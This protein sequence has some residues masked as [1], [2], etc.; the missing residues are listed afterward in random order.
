MDRRREPRFET[1]TRVR[2]TL[3]G[4]DEVALDGRM[5]EISDCGMRLMLDRPLPVSAA[6]RVDYDDTLLLGEVCHATQQ[7]EDYVVGLALD[8]VLHELTK[9]NQLAQ[10][11][12]DDSPA[13]ARSKN[14]LTV[15][16]A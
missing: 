3:L 5:V 15:K 8:Q 14:P 2:V 1:S 9:L 7:G 10:A 12:L 11:F 13:S 16:D 6:V 4:D